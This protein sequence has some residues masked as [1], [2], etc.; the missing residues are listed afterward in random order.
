MD[1]SVTLTKRQEAGVAAAVAAANA[2]LPEGAP[3]YTAETYLAARVQDVLNSYVSQHA[4][5]SYSPTGFFKLFTQDERIAI[6][7]A[8]KA[9][10]RIADFLSLAES[11]P[12]ISILD[13]D[14][15]AG[16]T[17]LETAG[18]LGKG[19]AAEILDTE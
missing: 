7:S 4:V 18:L 8:A 5:T 15:I 14:T 17:L 2:E 3:Q 13:P 19:R 16:V 11:A 9:E 6:R 10:P 1:F 12:S